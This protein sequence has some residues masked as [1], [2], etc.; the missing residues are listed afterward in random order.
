MN[1]TEIES[2][3][4]ARFQI[5]QCVG[6]GAYGVVW[7]GV[8]K[9]SQKI[10]AIKKCFDAFRNSTDAQ[11][12]FREVKYLQAL[13]GHENIIEL[14]QVI[15]SENCRDLYLIFEFMA[16]DLHAVMRAN[17]LQPIHRKFVTYQI[18]KALKFVHSAGLI[19]RDIKPS[20]ILLDAKCHVKLCD[21]GLA[22]SV[23][24]ASRLMTDY[25]ATR[26]Y[27]SP[28]VLVGST[29]YST[30]VDIW[31]VGCI[32]GEMLKKKPL[33]PG[34]NTLN[35]I[36]K[37]L[38]MHGIPNKDV[39]QTLT[40]DFAEKI[41]TSVE[42]SQS[43]STTLTKLCEGESVETLEFMRQC[44]HFVPNMRVSAEMALEH[45]FIIQFHRPHKEPS[46]PKD[47]IEVSRLNNAMIR[48]WQTL[49]HH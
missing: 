30:A 49:L 25:I 38:E 24:N 37:I 2:K 31:A 5:N 12:T 9:H 10:V 41:F 18:M 17:L 29:N 15:S 14:L 45:P 1:D 35:Q 47:C 4:L 36:E 22:R 32:L 11:R 33:F 16:T 43:S 42:V 28:E 19:H 27:R 21:F 40:S 39:I 26:W 48:T 20:N 13:R 6:R 34:H 46:Y 44:L 7:K 23:K 8:D 3:V